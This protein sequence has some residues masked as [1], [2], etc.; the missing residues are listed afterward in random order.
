[1][2]DAQ[3]IRRRRLLDAV[4]TDG[5]LRVTDA[6]AILGVSEVT[7]R[8][9]LATLEASGQIARVHGGALAVG[10]RVEDPVETTSAREAAAK[11]DIGRAAAALVSPGQCVVLDVGSTALAV[12]HALVDRGDLDDLIVVTNGLAIALALE[13]AVP[14]ITV[15]V[16]GGTLRPLQHSLVDPFAASV[17]DGLSCDL[18]I[19][20]CNGVSVERGVTN[21]N[22]PETDVKRRM[23]RTAR[24]V[25][26]V[27]D[28][29][30]LGV[31]S[32]GVVAELADVHV[33]VTDRPS[34][35]SARL[36]DAGLEVVVARP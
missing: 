29:T 35:E 5:F 6:A 25:M 1:M 9:D 31:A 20:G 17:L 4:R 33:L 8:A 23:V 12:A 22:L 11:R 14:R 7:V 36:E 18:A 2:A 24:R 30:K 16:T 34:S 21:V 27:A 26:V 15:V 13:P 10:S 32:L 19:I 28:S 3:P